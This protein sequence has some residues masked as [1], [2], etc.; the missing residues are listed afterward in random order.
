MIEI[1][2]EDKHVLSFIKPTGLLSAPSE[3]ERSCVGDALCEQIGLSELFLVHRLDRNVSGVMLMAKNRGAAGKFSAL[4]SERSFEKEYLAVLHGTPTESRGVYKDLL[5]KD[6]RSNKTFV[7]DRVRKGVKDASLEYRVLATRESEDGEL[8]LVRIKLH[9]GRTH[10]IRVQFSSR[11]TPLFG[12]G[13]YGSHTNAGSIGLFSARLGF[14]HPLL[15]GK[16]VDIC[17]LPDVAVY[18][19]SLFGDVL[20]EKI[21]AE[22]ILDGA[23]ED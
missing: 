21:F 9:T 16:R 4:V 10:Q 2:Y 8:S 13:K 15:K 22:P 7:C 6:S 19:W 5:F 1:L 18:P 11:G 23:K 12:D 14:S 20:T 17:A 3:T